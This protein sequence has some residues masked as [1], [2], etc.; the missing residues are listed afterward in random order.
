MRKLDGKFSID[1]ERIVNTVS[2]EEI[3]LDE[4]VFLLRAR[5]RNAVAALQK[6]R[7]VCAMDECKRSHVEALNR[8]I[9][10]S[11][12]FWREHPGRMKQP[13][14]TEHIRMESPNA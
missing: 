6:Y 13:G 14:I 10:S 12:Q 9:D 5:D 3:P 11:I 7:E 1:G 4:P 8:T 2:G